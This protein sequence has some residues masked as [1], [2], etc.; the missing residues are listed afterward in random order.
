M[1]GKRPRPDEELTPAKKQRTDEPNLASQPTQPRPS[2]RQQERSSDESRTSERSHT[3]GLST[4]S[5]DSHAETEI[6]AP[7]PSTPAAKMAANTTGDPTAFDDYYYGIG[8]LLKLLARSNP[9]PWQIPL[10]PGYWGG[11]SPDT[12]TIFVVTHHPLRQKLDAGLRD[13]ILGILATMKPRKWISVDYLRIGYDKNV[14]QNNPV[15]ALITVEK[16]QVPLAEAQRVVDAIAE[17][18]KR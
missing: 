17:E 13:T 6:T 9:E 12:K 18:C 8:R 5:T 2:R 15:V 4:F 11:P 10:V 3:T 1:P 7:G 16:D 14:A